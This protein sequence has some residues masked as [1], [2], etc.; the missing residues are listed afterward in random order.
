MTLRLDT[1]LSM[2]TGFGCE[3]ENG[4]SVTGHFS[5]DSLSLRGRNFLVLSAVLYLMLCTKVMSNDY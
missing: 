2:D 4:V 1:G 3:S 5:D